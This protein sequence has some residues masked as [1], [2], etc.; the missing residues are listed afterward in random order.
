MSI[1]IGEGSRVITLS[2]F[3]RLDSRETMFART[4]KT[5]TER[6]H[7]F[8]ADRTNRR[9]I[10]ESP[11]VRFFFIF[12]RNIFK[13]NSHFHSRRVVTLTVVRYQKRRK[14]ISLENGKNNTSI[15]LRKTMIYLSNIVH[16]LSCRPTSCKRSTQEK[17]LSPTFPFTSLFNVFTSLLLSFLFV[18]LIF[19]SFLRV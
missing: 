19:A 12:F 17:L 6:Q 11:H 7:T 1:E 13:A 15:S 8:F 18:S 5:S 3:F 2:D 14:E 16:S 4:L 9:V 10:S